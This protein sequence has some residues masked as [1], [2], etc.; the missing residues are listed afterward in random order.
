MLNAKR[1]TGMA[2]TDFLKNKKSREL[3]L[4]PPPSP[5][6]TFRGD[7]DSIRAPQAP[8][9]ELSDFSKDEPEYDSLPDFPPSLPAPAEEKE[10]T[11]FDKTHTQEGVESKPERVEQVRMLPRAAFIAMEDYKRIVND[12]NSI[13]AHVM[14]A[15]SFAKKLT[16]LKT[17][18]ERALERWRSHLED[19]EKKLAY[20]DQLI[21]KAEK[22]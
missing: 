10:V 22:V 13:R 19:V 12:T 1:K 20:V 15:E 21:E 18:E 4:P 6:M 16:E 3:P 9:P 11:V 17:D 5:P 2:F 14:N 8:M 7:F